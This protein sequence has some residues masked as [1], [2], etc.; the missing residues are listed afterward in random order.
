[1]YIEDYIA[2]RQNPPKSEG[3]TLETEFT[4]RPKAGTRK[5][6][7]FHRLAGCVFIG[8]PFEASEYVRQYR[9]KRAIKHEAASPVPYRQG[10]NPEFTR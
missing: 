8:S 9:A 10:Q 6:Q 1:M 5:V 2:L 7:V 3:L 4:L